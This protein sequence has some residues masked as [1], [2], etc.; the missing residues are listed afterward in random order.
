MGSVAIVFDDQPS[1]V[2][3]ARV[4]YV[5]PENFIYETWADEPGDWSWNIV[6][7]PSELP[8]PAPASSDVVA[9]NRQGA[10]NIDTHL[11][12]VDVNGNLAHLLWDYSEAPGIWMIRRP[13]PGSPVA[14]RG[15]SLQQLPVPAA[16]GYWE[17]HV[18]YT[19]DDGNLFEDWQ[20]AD[21]GDNW[22]QQQLPTWGAPILST[23]CSSTWQYSDTSP[24]ELHVY[25]FNHFGELAESWWDG[26]AW[27]SQGLPGRL[28]GAIP[29][30]RAVGQHVFFVGEGDQVQHSW[31]AGD[32]WL[33]E[34]VNP[35]FNPKGFSVLAGSYQDS[36]TA[37]EQMHVFYAG[38]DGNLH[39]SWK[40]LNYGIGGWSHGQL[41]GKPSSL[42]AFGGFSYESGSPAVYYA[43]KACRLGVTAYSTDISPINPWFNVPYLPGPP[44]LGCTPAT[45]IVP[46][47]CGQNP[48]KTGLS[49]AKAEEAIVGAGF[50]YSQSEDE[51]E[52]RRFLPFAESQDPDGDTEA[53]L[54]TVVNVTIAVPG[55]IKPQ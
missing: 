44:P 5:G 26:S 11:Y 17:T 22:S 13:L 23:L 1:Q 40:A 20:L 31:W 54:D 30:I 50:R 39:Q 52:G 36:D 3:G 51:I 25:Y 45:G 4:F 32:R 37:P 38:Q 29:T 18:F 9:E 19:Q 33:N 2:W 21:A 41:P 8:T 55:R 27:H 49:P 48:P 46:D 34:V 35:G 14:S 6:T 15:I 7:D 24:T 28:G 42:I 53:V 47:V 12:Y 16:E 43:D 10:V